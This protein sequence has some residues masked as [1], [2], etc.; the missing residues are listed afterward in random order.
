LVPMLKLCDNLTDI[1]QFMLGRDKLVLKKCEGGY[2]GDGVLIVDASSPIDVQNFIGHNE[3]FICEEY[4]GN[5]R[6]IAVVF[7]KTSLEMV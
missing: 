1:Q 7:A 2:N 3:P 4:I 5:K 6:E